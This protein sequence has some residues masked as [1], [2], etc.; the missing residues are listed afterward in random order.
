AAVTVLNPVPGGGTSNSGNFTIS[1]SGQALEGDVSPRPG[2]N[3]VVSLA[4]YV[5]I[6]R[7]AAG[8]DTVT[9][10]SEFQKA[11]CAPRSTLGDGVVSLA[12]WVQAGRWAAGL[13][14]PVPAAGGPTGSFASVEARA[15]ASDLVSSP[16][17]DRIVRAKSTTIT[18]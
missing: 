1:P 9:V 4:D 3:G 8:L 18:R 12:D 14:L 10:G 5:Q 11:D 15:A 6:G 7:F 16:E 13:D 17:Q 2:G